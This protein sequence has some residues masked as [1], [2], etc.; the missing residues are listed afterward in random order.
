MNRPLRTM[1]ADFGSYYVSG[2]LTN[3]S[4]RSS[5]ALS[6]QYS[7]YLLPAA[8]VFPILVLSA[9]LYHS[10]VA[11]LRKQEALEHCPNTETKAPA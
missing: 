4:W 2:C 11:H 3:P 7:S 10:P 1:I 9:S 8:T 6:L 5:T